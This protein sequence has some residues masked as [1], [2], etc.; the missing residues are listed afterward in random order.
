MVLCLIFSAGPAPA[1]RGGWP[2]GWLGAP[3]WPWP[4]PAGWW[5]AP[6]C[7][8]EAGTGSSWAGSPAT[9]YNHYK[10][11]Q[12]AKTYKMCNRFH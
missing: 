3:G 12:E 6:D 7:A 4:W 2:A 8:G 5:G 9:Y 11:N 1:G 10:R